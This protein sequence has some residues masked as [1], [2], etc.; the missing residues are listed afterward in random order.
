MA[1]KVS[2]KLF[3]IIAGV[4]LSLTG[5]SAEFCVPGTETAPQIDGII[6]AAEWSRALVL[7]GAG[8]PVDQRKSQCFISFDAGH[9]YVAVQ[10]ELPPKGK[11]VSSHSFI[12]CNDS[13]ELWFD[14]PK[15]LRTVEQGKFGE[16][17][18]IASF[19]NELQMLHHNPGYGLPSRTWKIDDF[20]SENHLFSTFWTAARNRDCDAASAVHF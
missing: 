7:A 5:V 4:I 16:F 3:G 18:L 13:I 14:P 11:L 20:S 1:G 10:S 12:V 8:T 17:Q 15:E 9:V 19:K 2:K 6:D